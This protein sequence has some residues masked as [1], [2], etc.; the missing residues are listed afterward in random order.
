MN[1]SKRRAFVAVS[2]ALQ[3]VV[4]ALVPQLSVKLFKRM[5]GKNFENAEQLEAKPAY[6][7]QLRALGV[8]MAVAGAVGYALER[9]AAE[10]EEEE[11]E[12]DEVDDQ[13]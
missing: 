8:G 4:T 6:L 1:Y 2:V 11:D 13:N 10:A 9:N 5:I 12:A 7:R 3:G